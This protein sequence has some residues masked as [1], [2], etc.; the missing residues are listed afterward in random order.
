MDR[1]YWTVRIFHWDSWTSESV[2]YFLFGIQR[3]L[4]SDFIY[5]HSFPVY[6]ALMIFR[7]K[8]I[9]KYNLWCRL[10]IEI[11]ILAILV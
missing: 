10:K 6:F 2:R 4:D 1:F 5:G 3:W 8:K 7:E 11:G 9:F